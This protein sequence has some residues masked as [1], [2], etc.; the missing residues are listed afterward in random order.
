MPNRQFILFGIYMVV[1]SLS[2]CDGS[3]YV[4]LIAED[5]RFSPDF[6]RAKTSKPI[7]LSVY[8]AGRETHE[9]D[10]RL[11]RYGQSRVVTTSTGTAGSG[12]ILRPGQ[13]VRIAITPP[14]GTY[15]YQCRRKGHRSMSG[16]IILE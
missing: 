12:V 1:Q 8:N 16:T 6:V 7:I 10:S 15:I 14:P 13:S 11:L 3:Q 2:A 5:F 4:S 9:F